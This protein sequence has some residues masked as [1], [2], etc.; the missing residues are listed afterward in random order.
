MT[1]VE[2]MAARQLLWEEHIG[3]HLRAKDN[4]KSSEYAKSV[5]ALRKAG[6]SEV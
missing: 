6:L 4:A 1:Y 3:C 5:S 2:W